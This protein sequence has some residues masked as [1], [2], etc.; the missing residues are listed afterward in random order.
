VLLW[1]A[2]ASLHVSC[3]P[4]THAR[5]H[6]RARAHTHTHIH[7]HTHTHTRAR[8]RARTARSC[9]EAHLMFIMFPSVQTAIW[10]REHDGNK[11]M[12]W[13]YNAWMMFH[14]VW[15]RNDAVLVHDVDTNRRALY[16]QFGLPPKECKLLR[17][18]K[19]YTWS[20]V[21]WS[22]WQKWFVRQC[23]SRVKGAEWLS[24]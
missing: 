15:C 6:A 13:N 16:S 24:W 20:I 14:G 12:L 22:R 3:T 21:C 1:N 19:Y 11:A 2:H 10:A 23:N 17:S 7:I 5:T 9:C 8:A 18:L 4:Q